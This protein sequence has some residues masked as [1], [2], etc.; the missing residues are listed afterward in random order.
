MILFGIPDIRLF[1]S[2][3]ERFT[4]QFE[5]GQIARFRPYSKY[6]PVFKDLS[7]WLPPGSA[8]T[9]DSPPSSPPSEPRAAEKSAA[10]SGGADAGQKP[11][12]AAAEEP[13]SPLHANDVYEAIR[14]GAAEGA[15]GGGGG[16]GG[17]AEDW[18]ERVELL[19]EF[20]HPK[21]GRVSHCYRITYRSMDRS[22]TNEEIDGLQA[23]VRA[24]VADRLGVELR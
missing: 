19:D 6:P 3:D 16:G 13:A 5:S 10:A 17:G 7:F 22:L 4:S 11:D 15:E 12:S 24:H 1:W 23:R 21:T 20:V 9:S 8:S 18:I 2:T 14:S